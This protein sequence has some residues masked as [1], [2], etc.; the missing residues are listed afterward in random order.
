MIAVS[1][2]SVSP[3][4]L[5]HGLTSSIQRIKTAYSLLVHIETLAVDNIEYRGLKNVKLML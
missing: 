4:N 1:V 3:G 2:C 5:E